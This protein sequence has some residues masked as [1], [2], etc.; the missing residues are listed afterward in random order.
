MSSW[1]ASQE[2][3]IERKADVICWESCTKFK[4]FIKINKEAVCNNEKTAK[5]KWNRTK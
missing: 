1:K 3:L 5:K 4:K 2:R